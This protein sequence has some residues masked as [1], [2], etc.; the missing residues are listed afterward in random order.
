M[1]KL[2]D[3]LNGF[4]IQTII[5]MTVVLWYF[6][7]D[8]RNEIKREIDAIRQENTVQANRSDKLYEMFIALLRERDL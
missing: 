7:R 6:T 4:N 5:A 3:F 1:D 2:L 8:M